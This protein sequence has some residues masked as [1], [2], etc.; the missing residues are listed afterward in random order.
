MELRGEARRIRCACGQDLRPSFS[1]LQNGGARVVYFMFEVMV[2]GGRNVMAETLEARRELPTRE[3]RKMRINRS[4]DF[5]IGGYAKGG[6][7]FDAITLGRYEGER[8]IYVS[9]T[10]NGFTPTADGTAR[11][12]RDPRMPVSRIPWG[13]LP[14]GGEKGSRREDEGVRVGAAGGRGPN[15]NLW[16]GRRTGLCG[17]ADPA[18]R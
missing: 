3:H 10:R 8:L 7:T 16:S 11:G 18:E 2:L 5:A 15:S 4:A 17:T 6:R 13:A 14:P 9:R 1:A 12:D